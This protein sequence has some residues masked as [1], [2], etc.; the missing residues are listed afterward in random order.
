MQITAVLGVT[1]CRLVETYRSFGG[2]NTFSKRALTSTRLRRASDKSLTFLIC[3][4]TKRIFLGSV[5]E[6]RKNEVCGAQGSKYIFQSR[7]LLIY[8]EC[9]TL[10]SPPPRIQCPI[11]EDDNV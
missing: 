5:K 6:I 10:I 2:S 3:S 7:S 9:Q 11:L 8:L 1:L 4:T